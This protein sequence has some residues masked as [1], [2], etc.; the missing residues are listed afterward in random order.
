MG[1]TSKKCK[2]KSLKFFFD[3]SIKINWKNA[4][5]RSS[6]VISMALCGAR[7]ITTPHTVLHRGNPLVSNSFFEQI[8]KAKASV[9]E[10]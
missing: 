1:D 7:E 5:M 10:R 8:L 2:F 6:G 9:T 4:D 3:D